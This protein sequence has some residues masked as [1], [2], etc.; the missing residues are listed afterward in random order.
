MKVSGNKQ[1][2]ILK[3]YNKM[4]GTELEEEEVKRNQL[5]GVHLLT[6]GT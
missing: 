1:V 2:M 3:S 5:V 6:L 4:K